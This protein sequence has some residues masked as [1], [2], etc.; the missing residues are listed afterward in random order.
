MDIEG[1]EVP[2]KYTALI[3]DDMPIIRTIEQVFLAARGFNTVVVENGKEA[4][5]LFA[6]GNS[7][8][9]VL[10]DLEMPIMNGIQVYICFKSLLGIE[11]YWHQF[12]INL[13]A[14]KKLQLMITRSMDSTSV[15]FRRPRFRQLTPI[16]VPTGTASL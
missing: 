12:Q 14:L 11:I 9:I 4:V 7:F 1:S 15:W 3:V 13:S 16:C 10:M 6:A 8:D 5:D 2:M